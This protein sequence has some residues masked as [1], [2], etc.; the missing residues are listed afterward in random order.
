MGKPKALG[1]DGHHPLSHPKSLSAS[2]IANGKVFEVQEEQIELPS[3]QQKRFVSVIH[4]GAVV[5]LPQLANGRFVLLRQ[6]RHALR[7]ELYEFPAG[8]LE[9]GEDPLV[10]AKREIVEEI[11][12]AAAEWRSLGE[13]YPAP[14]FC[15]ELQYCYFATGLSEQR[16]PG[17]DDEILTVVTASYDEIEQGIAHGQIIDAKSI[18]VFFKAKVMGL[19]GGGR[20]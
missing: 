16:A 13:Q 10:C 2:V 20:S 4:P 19:I 7:Q 1:D 18:A 3:G 12:Y 5:V 11:G 6:Y 9:R 15:N 17:D 8:T 14:G